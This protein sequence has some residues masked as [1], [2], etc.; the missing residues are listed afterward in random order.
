MDFTLAEDQRQAIDG[1]RRFVNA[2]V[3]PL[4]K[5][6]YDAPAPKH[7]V[8][9][10]FRKLS[11]FGLGNG[12]TPEQSGGLGLDL[13]TSGLLYEELS[14]ASSAFAAAVCVN[15]SVSM[16]LHHQGTADQKS[17]ILPGLLSGEMI[18]SIAVTEPG[19]GSNSSA[20]K[21]RAVRHGAA[22][23]LIGEKTWIT[24][25]HVSDVVL[26]L[27]RMEDK[28]TFV[29]VERSAGYESHDIHKLGQREASSA[30][31]F[32]D[33]IEVPF[34]SIVGEPGDA[35]RAV[36]QLFERARCMVGM[37]ATGVAVEALEEAV[38]YAKSRT[39]WGKAIAGHQMVQ[40]LLAEMATDVECSRL[41]SL[42]A[43]N[44]IQQGIRK[45]E[46]AAMAKWYASEAA[47]RVASNAIQV[48]GSY[49]L[50]CEYPM[51]RLLRDARML[52]IPDGTTQIQ[53]LIIGRCMTGIAAFA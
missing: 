42:R 34:T 47:V 4:A 51:E 15:D 43:L 24:N 12:W 17:R 53:K 32:F 30:Q 8:L 38:A 6:H 35:V 41:L 18:G 25:G 52:T 16:L 3:R 50:S 26:V 27:C 28:P 33:E 29:L 2:E 49:G 23:K 22:L 14:R 19:I 31:L 20:V 5:T 40:G 48:F 39:Q 37:Y 44:Y 45:E 10:L 46:A 21:T 7:V 36:A 9:E 1:F 11:R 13:L